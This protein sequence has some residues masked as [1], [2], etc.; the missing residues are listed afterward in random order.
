[1]KCMSE[2]DLIDRRRFRRAREL[3]FDILRVLERM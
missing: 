1:M 3:I 2:I